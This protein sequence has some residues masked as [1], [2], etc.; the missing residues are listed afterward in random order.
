[1]SLNYIFYAE[2]MLEIRAA[3]RLGRPLQSQ[4]DEL[5]RF[6]RECERNWRLND[7]ADQPLDRPRTDV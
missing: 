5:L 6:V 3:R 7:R 1:M 2:K 4:L